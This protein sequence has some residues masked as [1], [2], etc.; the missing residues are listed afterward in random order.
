MQSSL[1]VQRPPLPPQLLLLLLKIDGSWRHLSG[2]AGYN[3]RHPDCCPAALPLD[4]CV[5]RASRAV[6]SLLTLQ[7]DTAVA[8]DSGLPIAVEQL[9]VG[10]RFLARPGDRIACDGDVESGDS[11][12]DQSMLTGAGGG[13]LCAHIRHQCLLNAWPRR[14]A[15]VSSQ[16]PCGSTSSGISAATICPEVVQASL[17]SC[18][19]AG[20]LF[21][22]LHV[23]GC[24]LAALHL[25]LFELLMLCRCC[26]CAVS[27]L[28]CPQVRPA[29]W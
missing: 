10:N 19:L 5:S 16:R 8:A 14:T 12:V 28:R 6:A 4:R 11:V 2:H 29:P 1:L 24:C 7:P 18:G 13:Q 15:G 23:D 22:L 17:S 27:L 25:W 9:A 3:E 21:L 26:V 20:A